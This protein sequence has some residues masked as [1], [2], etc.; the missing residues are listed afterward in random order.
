[1]KK[2][3]IYAVSAAASASVKASVCS[4]VHSYTRMSAGSAVYRSVYIR[5]IRVVN[6]VD[7]SIYEY[8]KS[9]K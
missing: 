5:A 9:K 4:C 1:M 3:L 2:K 7:D 6:S 8:I